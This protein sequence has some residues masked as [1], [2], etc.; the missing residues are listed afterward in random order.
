M[1]K[2]YRSKRYIFF[3]LTWVEIFI[4]T[5]TCQMRFYISHWP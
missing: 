2:T 4:S 5:R 1:R 3:V